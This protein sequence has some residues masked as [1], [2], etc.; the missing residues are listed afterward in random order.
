MTTDYIIEIKKLERKISD[1]TINGDTF[2]PGQYYGMRV[3]VP[4]NKG[5]QEDLTKSIQ[6]FYSLKFI[7]PGIP[8]ESYYLYEL[9]PK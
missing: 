5:H 3:R 7:E 1:D 6:N 2:M 4:L 8:Q 9:H